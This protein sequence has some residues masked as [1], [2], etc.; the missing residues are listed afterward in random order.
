MSNPGESTRNPTGYPFHVSSSTGPRVPILNL[1]TVYT[2]MDSLQQFLSE[3]VNNNTLISKD[4]MD[5]VS[6][7]IS[8]AIHQIIVNA[9]ALLSSSSSSS[10]PFMPQPPVESTAI[11]KA[12]VLKVEN[13]EESEE[14]TEAIELDAVELLAEH[15]HFCDICGKG[16]KR[17]TNLRMHMRAHGNQF[18]TLEALAKPD[19]GDKT[20]SV[21]LA[22][23][24]KFSCPFEGCNRNKKHSKFKPLMSVIC[25]RNHF[26]RSHCPKMYSCNRC[27]KKS[28]SVLADL[29]SHLKHC[30]ESRWKC[31]F[32]T[33]FSRKDKLF[34]HMALFEGHMPAVVGEEAGS[35]AKGLVVGGAVATEED[36][37]EEESVV[38][39]D[40]L[41]DNEFFEG[42]LFGFGPMEGYNSQ[43][44]WG[45]L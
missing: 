42:L 41:V 31:S 4:Q 21:S 45:L 20:I 39:G 17:D 33:S 2:R 6:S 26:K 9:A 24:T 18:K 43:D 7:E 29:K 19:K 5:M 12:Q 16:F 22:G 44:V 11:K 38:K 3:S 34:G 23:K 28:F 27:D 36:E 10:Q 40:D 15:V 13:R 25:V 14:D 1:S 32:G 8:S 35:K 30:G 37:E